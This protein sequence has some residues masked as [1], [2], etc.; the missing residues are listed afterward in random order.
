MELELVYLYPVT[1]VPAVVGR[2]SILASPLLKEFEEHNLQFTS[3]IPLF[4]F[5]S[6]ISKFLSD[7]SLLK[8]NLSYIWLAVFPTLTLAFIAALFNEELRG[9]RRA[10]VAEE[11]DAGG[12]KITR[13]SSRRWWLC[14]TGCYARWGSFMEVTA[15]RCPSFFSSS[16]PR[17]GRWR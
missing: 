2:F 10:A 4:F 8:I 17:W 6:Y 5:Y 15:L 13:S 16:A 1:L 11:D 3:I 7:L 12:G 9:D 14:P